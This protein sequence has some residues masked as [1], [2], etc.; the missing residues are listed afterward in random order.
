MRHAVFSFAKSDNS[1]VGEG[2]AERDRQLT[3]Y[4]QVWTLFF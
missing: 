4:H 1:T 2:E 3:Q